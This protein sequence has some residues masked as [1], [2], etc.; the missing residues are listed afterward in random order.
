MNLDIL[1]E[2][3]NKRVLIGRSHVNVE[4]KHIWGEGQMIVTTK[5]DAGWQQVSLIKLRSYICSTIIIH[6]VGFKR[7]SRSII[8]TIEPAERVIPVR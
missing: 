1:G 6:L 4:K 7:L 3:E 8:N 2:P 5:V